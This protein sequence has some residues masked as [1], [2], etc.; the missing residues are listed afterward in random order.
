MPGP[1]S[2]IFAYAKE[3]AYA[4]KLEDNM[5]KKPTKVLLLVGWSF[6]PQGWVKLNTDGASKGNP[7]LAG[8][9]GL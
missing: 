2:V 4:M 5:V 6:P 8:A 3:V 9:G 7:G 1:V